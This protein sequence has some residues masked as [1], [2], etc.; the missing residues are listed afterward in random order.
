MAVIVIK[1]AQQASN[2]TSPITITFGGG[3]TPVIEYISCEMDFNLS[4]QKSITNNVALA[5]G[6]AQDIDTI[7]QLIS[8]SAGSIG[9]NVYFNYLNQTKSGTKECSFGW[10]LSAQYSIERDFSW[11]KGKSVGAKSCIEWRGKTATH[12]SNY[13]IYYGLAE[14]KY[15]CYRVEHP[16]AG[17]IKMSLNKSQVSPEF[18]VTIKMMP[19]EKVCYWGLPGGPVRSDD[20]I[21]PI[22]SKIPIEP[23]IQ[24][25]YIM[26]PSISCNRLSDD[27]KILINSINITWQRGQ[28]AATGNIK[29]CSRIDME[30]AIGQQLKLVING[31]EFVVICEQPST[32]NRFANN[33]YSASIRSRFAELAAPYQRERNYVNTVDKTLAGIM[34]DI[35]E[36][37]GWT[38]DNKMIDYPIPEGAFSYRGLT[39]AA[40]LLKVASSIGAILDINDTIKTV[41]VVPEW[42]VNPWSTEQATPDVILNDALILEHNT[43][44][45]IQPEHNVVFVRGEQQGVACKIKRQNTPATDYARDIV[46]N[47]I[48][49][50]QAAR[51]RGTCELARSGNKRTATIR[52]KLKADLPPIRPGMLLGVRFEDELYKATVDSLAISASISNQGAIMVNQ[53]IQAVRNV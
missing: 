24:R 33:S 25:Y 36:N 29:F 22:D 12:E 28:F 4:S 52:T 23:Q 21:P 43:R 7:N 46:D 20:D 13:V 10:S 47:L 35:L 37:T 27:L 34:T 2:K 1:L 9:N 14:R 44:D 38:L 40:A 39:P 30:R 41:S 18:R 3:D 15:I 8:S 48:T 49:D 42:P 51:Q 50:V 32:S 11:L 31:Y 53:T 5:F 17:S 26:Q 16:K 45:T 6:R 19:I